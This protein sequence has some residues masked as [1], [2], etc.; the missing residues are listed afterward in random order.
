MPARA[1]AC[2]SPQSR[3]PVPVRPA[4]VIAERDTSGGHPN[5]C[6]DNIDATQPLA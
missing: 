6:Q 5:P 2:A 1:R 4:L 3:V